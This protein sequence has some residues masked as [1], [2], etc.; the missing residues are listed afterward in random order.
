[1]STSQGLDTSLIHF[2]KD[3]EGKLRAHVLA[4]RTYRLLDGRVPEVAPE[5]LAIVREPLYE[6][7]NEDNPVAWEPDFYACPRTGT[8]VV[9]LGS[10][11]CREG[12]RRELDVSVS[13]DLGGVKRS[14]PERVTRR[15]RVFGDRKVDWY[16][17]SV[18]FT[19][20][21]PF[22]RMPLTFRRAYG[23][24]D[25]AADEEHPDDFAS[26]LAKAGDLPMEDIS[27]YEYPRNP[28]GKGYVVF[29]DRRALD[30]LELP[31]LEMPG[32]LLTPENL[33]LGAAARWPFAPR[34]AGFGFT[35]QSWFPRNAF[36]GLSPSFEGELQEI[37]EV[38]EG[39]LPP[40]LLEGDIT[41]HL[42]SPQNLRFFH[43]AA[44]WLVFPDFDG[45]ETLRIANM[46]PSLPELVV[47]MPRERPLLLLEPHT[48]GAAEL[49]PALR[50]VVVRPDEE[51]LVLIW[52]GTLPVDRPPTEAQYR[53]MRHA[54]KWRS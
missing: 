50:T 54:V 18:H 10:A 11:F 31:N 51:Q 14:A 30:G 27:P 43:A 26:W 33:V 45:D 25:R 6:D 34:P 29:P 7:G 48:G 22:E 37:P 42:G 1:M 15:V 21:E 32:A 41:D 44:P 13:V 35:D 12:P 23:G 40:E 52:V 38:R 39:Y 3:T 47:P 16:E 53:K 46:H 19:D 2:T 20:P 5:Q 24:H 9:V 49:A 4:K 28:A 36:L 8:D 17:G